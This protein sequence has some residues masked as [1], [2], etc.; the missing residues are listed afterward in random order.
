[1]PACAFCR[2]A[3]YRGRTILLT[4]TKDSGW[5]C[6]SVRVSVRTRHLAAPEVGPLIVDRRAA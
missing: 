5:N 6:N 3:G 4:Y 2:E 1:M